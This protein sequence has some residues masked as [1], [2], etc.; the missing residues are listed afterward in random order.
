MKTLLLLRHAEARRAAAGESDFARPLSDPGRAAAVAVGRFLCQER[1]EPDVILCSPAERA[2]Q[3]TALVCEAAG[4]APKLRH[5][6][7]IYEA[8]AATLCEV[9]SQIGERAATA[10]LVGHNP[11]LSELLTR[12]T[13][14]TPQLPPTGLALIQLDAGKW[15]QVRVSTGRLERLVSPPALA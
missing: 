7:R 2:R 15:A 14:E 12:L 6:A 4:L 11:G 10:L 1:V 5:D 9:V 13:G 8:T 3:T